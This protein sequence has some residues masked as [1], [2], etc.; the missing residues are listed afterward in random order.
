MDDENK[1]RIEDSGAA[2]AD[3]LDALE[4]RIAKLEQNLL[5]VA[6]AI[7]VDKSLKQ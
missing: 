1:V 6:K 4:A 7:G 3:D 2:L 5:I